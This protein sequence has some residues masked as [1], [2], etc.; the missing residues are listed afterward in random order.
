MAR[1]SITS[2]CGRDLE[3][4]GHRSIRSRIPSHRAC[5]RGVRRPVP[6]TL[7]GQF[8]IGLW[9]AAPSPVL[10][11]DRAGI[12]RCSTPWRRGVY[13]FASEIKALFRCPEVPRPSRV[14]H[15]DRSSPSGLCWRPN[16]FFPDQDAAPP[17]IHGSR[18]GRA[19]PRALLGWA[20][21]EEPVDDAAHRRDMRENCA[22]AGRRGPPPIAADVPVGRTSAAG[23][24]PPVLTTIIKKLT[25]T[26]C[27]RSR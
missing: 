27:E 13:C 19:A 15:W 5:V 14:A 16:T 18:V 7:N 11:R 8:A 1:F 24:T 26:H 3:R 6:R 17:G 20:F 10:A 4:A 22:P 25:D 2:S 9:I 12:R 21:P 23:S